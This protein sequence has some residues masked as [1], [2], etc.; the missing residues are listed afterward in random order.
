MAFCPEVLL[1]KLQSESIP[2]DE[3]AR[4]RYETLLGSIL[5]KYVPAGKASDKL[6]FEAINGFIERN[7][8]LG[9]K[10]NIPHHRLELFN[11]WQN[12]IY[13]VMMTGDYQ[14]SVLDLG[15]CF[16]FGKPGPGST[17]GTKHTSF[18]QKMFCSDLTYTNESLLI[19]YESLLSPRWA[20]ADFTRRMLYNRKQ[21]AGSSLTTVRKDV[22]KDRCICT[23]PAINMFYQLGAK[24][25]LNTVLKRHFHLDVS[26]QPDINKKLAQK[27]SLDGSNAT[28]DLSD[29][30]DHI[31]YDLVKQL[32][33]KPCFDVLNL[34]RSENFEVNGK[35]RKFNMISSM[36]NG[37]TFSLMT[38]IIVS[39]L[40]VFL[41]TKQTRYIP[42]RDGVFG[43]D[44][45]MP[46]Q[47]A[48]EFCEVLSDF[49]LKVNLNKSFIT[50][51][52]R[53]S[54]GGDY[55]NGFNVRGVYIKEINNEASIYSA[56]NRLFSWSV[57]YGIPITNTLAYVKSLVKF[58]PVP[59]HE[60]E[61]AGIRVPYEFVQSRKSD[62]N[63]A[64]YYRPLAVRARQNR[65][66]DECIN[67][68]G[69]YVSALGGY[70]RAHTYTVRSNAPNKYKVIKRKTPN[71][72]FSHDP[73]LDARDACIH[74]AAFVTA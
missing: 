14:S 15:S 74:W 3:L 48:T 42:I 11:Q 10:F 5:K 13:D 62:Q 54:C 35:V 52:F 57:R 2:N 40:D 31:H 71:W 17:R 47:Y 19:H 61:D 65:I 22:K 8:G 55:L 43:D 46:S 32:F 68:T 37:F 9:D 70:I 50:G 38:L 20:E 53:E 29:A 44:I 28:I 69:A 60:S 6:R 66:S 59:L 30:S 33:P 23:E 16:L 27:G 63:G 64:V 21:V 26:T 56:F 58:R 49:G 25:V 24:Q 51:P 18:Y 7:E 4:F 34:I 73:E 12:R 39:L 67:S 41:H 45:I 1:L 72:N 36:G